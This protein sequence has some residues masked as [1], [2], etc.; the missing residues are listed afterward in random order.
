MQELIATGMDLV[1]DSQTSE[2][3]KR[4][5]LE[6]IAEAGEAIWILSFNNEENHRGFLTSKTLDALVHVVNNCDVPN[7]FEPAICSKAVMWSLAALQNLAASYC[8]T[9]WGGCD[10]EW[11]NNGELVLSDQVKNE[12]G[13]QARAKLMAYLESS[14]LSNTLN[15]L[16]CIGPVDQPHGP[17][18]AW[19]SLSEIPDKAQDL[20]SLI[21]WAAAGLIKNLALSF[22]T[23]TFWKENHSMFKCLCHLSK[24]SPDWLE[25]LKATSA[26]YN[27]GWENT[28][29]KFHV[30]C[31]DL[32]HWQYLEGDGDCVG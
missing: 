16:V 12:V 26:L 29:P 11:D 8:H 14:D 22:H 3:D 20:P 7:R 4:T 27:L 24:S 6:A 17:E 23:R 5:A 15:H 28:C 21:P 31:N 2:H 18:H 9:D 19:P 25:E 13:A 32:P 10:W 30:G 1:S